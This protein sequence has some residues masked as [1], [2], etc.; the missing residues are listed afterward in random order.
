MTANNTADAAAYFARIG[1]IGPREP[2]LETLSA[3][4]THHVR[5]I[6][7]ENLDVLLGRGIRLDL[8]SIEQ[9]LV[10]QR[11]GGYCFEQNL[12]FSAVLRDLGFAV[13]PRL[14]RV[15]WKVPPDTPTPLTHMVLQVDINARP[16]LADVGFGGIGLEKPIA[17]D[18]QA[19]QGLPSEPRRLLREGRHFQHQV[20]FGEAW[21]ELYRFTLDDVSPIDFEVA[22]WFTSTH[23]ESRFKQNIIVSRADEGRRLTLFNREFNIRHL[24]GSVER[25]AIA[26]PAELIERLANSFGLTFPPDTQFKCPA[27]FL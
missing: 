12:L 6:P 4:H 17:L 25:H 19:E 7:F 21:H 23:P 26:S 9:K 8:P 5:A 24:G 16:W 18:T 10:G 15:R 2:T 3:I 27:A 13:M 11:R 20:R 1:Y 14:A 22:N